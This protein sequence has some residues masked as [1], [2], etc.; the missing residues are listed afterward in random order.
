MFYALIESPTGDAYHVTV[1]TRA[2]EALRVGDLVSLESKREPAVKPIDRHLAEVAA[3]RGGVYTAAANGDPDE[4]RR[5]AR[6]LR[7]L[8]RA[9]LVSPTPASGQWS[10]PSN[11]LQQLE[12]RH[13]EAAGRFRLSVEAMPLGIDAQTH[14]RG[15]VWLDTVDAAHLSPTG[16]GAEVRAALERRRQML[17]EVGLAPNAPQRGAPVVDH[18]RTAAPFVAPRPRGPDRER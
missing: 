5:A 1:P 14:H 11:L 18:E 8:E 13:R 10:V 9:G 12:K 6:R 4:V 3:S 15:P 7:E 17:R 2:A 16:F